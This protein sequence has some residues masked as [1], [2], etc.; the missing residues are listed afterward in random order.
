M[1]TLAGYL[2]NIRCKVDVLHLE[3][4]DAALAWR[5]RSRE[6]RA[7]WD[8]ACIGFEQFEQSYPDEVQV[9][10]EGE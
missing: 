7:A 8:F 2:S 1:T 4:G 5:G 3:S 9:R 6:A 10:Y